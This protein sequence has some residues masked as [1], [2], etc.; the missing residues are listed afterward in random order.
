MTIAESLLPEFDREMGLT[1]QLLERVPNDKANWKP[2]PKSFSLGDLSLH[3]AN[4]PTWA[5][6]T[7]KQTELDVNPP[8]GPGFAPLKFESMTTTLKFLD[9]NV[10]ATRSAIAGATDGEM[11]VM[12]TFKNGGKTIFSMPRIAVLRSFVMNHMIHHR[13][14]LTV[15]LRE[16]DVPLPQIYGPTADSPL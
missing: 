12:W 3:I 8:G 10:R 11:M 5:V 6:S 16:L 14:Q 2:H 4:L 15:Y 13:G 7:M 1:R 9:D